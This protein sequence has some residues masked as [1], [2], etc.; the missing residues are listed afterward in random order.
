MHN[1]LLSLTSRIKGSLFK[2]KTN[3]NVLSKGTWFAVSSKLLIR[4]N[5]HIELKRKVTIYEYG[6]IIIEDNG[7]LFINESSCVERGSEIIVYKDASLCI[8]KNTG[9]GSYCNIRATGKIQ[10]GDNVLIA[11]FVS[12]IDGQ[13][14]YKDKTI[15]FG[16][17]H[18]KV[19]HV[20]IGNNVWIGIGAILLPGVT[21]GD[22]AVIGA[23]SVVTKDIPPYAVAFG[24]PARIWESRT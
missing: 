15:I 10:I 18:F 16:K 22:G 7:K 17:E 3:I 20:C 12:I 21:I 6:K 23:G 13:Y 2:I 5:A 14:E 11:Q 19:E 4:R 1:I 24:S 8:G 9:I